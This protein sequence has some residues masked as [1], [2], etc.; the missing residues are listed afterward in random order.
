MSRIGTVLHRTRFYT[1]GAAGGGLASLLLYFVVYMYYYTYILA[2]SNHAREHCLR[3][4]RAE[5]GRIQVL[6]I[7]KRE[8]CEITA[9]IIIVS[10]N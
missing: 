8:A 7:R 1:A 2:E 4:D 5:E 10:R 3:S 9:E 6:L